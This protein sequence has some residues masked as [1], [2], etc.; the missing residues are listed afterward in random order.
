MKKILVTI[1]LG[2][3]ASN[4]AKYGICSIEEEKKPL[5]WH[6]FVPND[7]RHVKAILSQ[8][9]PGKIHLQFPMKSMHPITGGMFFT[10][11]GFLIESPKTI[12]EAITQ[13]LQ[14]PKNSV[15]APGIWPT[16]IDNDCFIV[17]MLG[18]TTADFSG[19][20]VRAYSRQKK[21]K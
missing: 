1:I 10:P 17:E 9:S 21:R 15:F 5:H 2:N 19:Q 12:P 7:H 3:P 11:S 18:L 20:Q 14:I 13:Q 4:C 16:R 8:P 6:Q